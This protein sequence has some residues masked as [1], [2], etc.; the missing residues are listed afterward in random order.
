LIVRILRGRVRPERVSAFRE[1][2][3]RVIVSARQS[4][5]I[6]F[7]QVGRQAHSD[8][9][10]EVA[11]VSVWRDLDSLY[12]WVGGTDL[13]E[14]PVL[15]GGLPDVLDNFEVQHF[16]TYEGGVGE[17]LEESLGRGVAHLAS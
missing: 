14:T 4:D 8:G 1:Q 3:E 6:V 5:G 13:L 9:T 10:E 2:S 11:F 7:A 15:S 12:R 16:E 17:P